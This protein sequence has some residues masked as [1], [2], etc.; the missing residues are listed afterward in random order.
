MSRSTPAHAGRR[1]R[2]AVFAG[3]CV[4]G[5]ATACGGDDSSTSAPDPEASAQLEDF[6]FTSWNYGED[7]QKQ[8]ITDEAAGFTDG[9][10]IEATL[11]SFPFA[12]YKNQIVLRSR[13]GEVTGAAQLDIADLSSLAQL[14]VLADLGAYAEQGGYTE[15]ALA[16]GQ[17]DGVQYGL[18]WYTGSIGLVSNTDLLAEAGVS[19]APA[20][21]ADF[22][23]ALRQVKAL[24]Q[25]Y[26][27]YAFTTKPETIKDVIP[28]FRTFGSPIVE[29]GEVKVNDPGAVE[30]LTWLKGL[31]DDGLIALN[32]GRPEARTLYAQGRT[33][34]FD[35]ANQVRG[36]LKSQA[37]DPAILEATAPIARP[38]VEPGD[39]PQSL[40]W[41]GLVVVFDS[42][43]VDTAAQFASFITSDPATGL[44]RYE[45]IGSAPTTTEALQDPSFTGDAYS[46]TW[47]T[48]ITDNAEPNPLWQFPAYG[49][50][51]VALATH[52]QAALLGEETPQ[53]ALDAANDEMQA[54]AK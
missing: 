31:L 34:F 26:V 14:G 18:P 16:N 25:D 33:A 40:A 28:W 38:V 5:L 3:I 53:D 46:S 35:D 41:G 49:Q 22:E 37:E 54:L 4:V 42:G 51:E 48:A 47:Q 23:D 17:Y 29:D 1:T 11:S 10:G 19:E 52:V 15:A 21:V 39:T 8:L 27:P 43:P 30:A 9:K 2:S 36:T 13:S 6:T 45:Q 12:E 32:I 20:T 50:M 7:A 24:G 44:T